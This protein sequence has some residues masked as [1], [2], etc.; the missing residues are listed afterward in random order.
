MGF[1]ALS[2][3]ATTNASRNLS[4]SRFLP[5]ARVVFYISYEING[6]AGALAKSEGYRAQ[7]IARAVENNIWVVQSNGVGPLQAT[8]GASLG[9]SRIVA[10]TGKVG[11]RSARHAGL[12]HRLGTP[13][14]A[15]PRGSTPS[16]ACRSG[17]LPSGGRGA[18]DQLRPQR[19]ASAPAP[20]ADKPSSQV[21]L[22]LMKAM[23]LKWDLDAN[24][25]VFLEQLDAASSAGAQ[26]FVTPECW[27][28]G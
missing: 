13:P 2:S 24:F 26:L 25:K 11:R 21:R 3:S 17:P 19:P 23:P 22:A 28:D 6:L 1:P 14:P 20:I 7:L 4:A 8:G 15:T 18:V 5:G 9:Y 12:Q 16:K 27:L 10:P